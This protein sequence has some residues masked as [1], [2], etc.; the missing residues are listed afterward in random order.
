MI[1]PAALL[2]VVA[3]AG[4]AGKQ[5]DLSFR[6]PPDA[7]PFATPDG[8]RLYWDYDSGREP[9]LD[10]ADWP[11]AEMRLSLRCDALSGRLLLIAEV[12]HNSFAKPRPAEDGAPLVMEFGARFQGPVRWM[13]MVDSAWPGTH[14][15]PTTAQLD[16]L[17]RAQTVTLQLGREVWRV[18]APQE[19]VRRHFA[20][21]CAD[22]LRIP[23]PSVAPQPQA[24]DPRRQ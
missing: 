14:F 11:S 10:L 6:P 16:A 12:W 19:A 2:A 1:R 3:L 23:R 9:K 22:A 4:C 7:E 5:P 21:Q 13:V 20:W 8:A 18:P 17:A 15:D 24:T